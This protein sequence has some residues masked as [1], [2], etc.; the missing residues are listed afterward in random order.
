MVAVDLAL[1]TVEVM[2]V[3]SMAAA[4]MALVALATVVAAVETAMETAAAVVMVGWMAAVAV[5]ARQ[6]LR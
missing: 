2:V 1:E 5:M 4:A 3:G 6:T